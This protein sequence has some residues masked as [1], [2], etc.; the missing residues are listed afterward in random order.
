MCVLRTALL[1]DDP[2]AGAEVV[3]SPKVNHS[4]FEA[5]LFKQIKHLHG[6]EIPLWLSNEA[7]A[8]SITPPKKLHATA[9]KR[10]QTVYKVRI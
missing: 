2:S 8:R 5:A 6:D 10:Y 3:E 4:G 9:N 1:N 7:S